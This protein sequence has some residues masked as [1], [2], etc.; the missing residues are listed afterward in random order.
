MP[1][2]VLKDI[3]KKEWD[4]AGSKFITFPPGAKPGDI[5]IREV[6]L[7]MVDWDTP[8]QSIKFPVTVTEEGIDNGKKDKVSAGV[9][10]KSVW[11]LKEIL[12]TLGVE[13]KVVNGKIAFDSDALTGMKTNGIWVMQKG[14][15]GG[16]PNA[17]EVVYPKLT[18]FVA[19]KP[20]TG[21]IM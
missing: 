21:T 6:E 11:K 9:D 12:N 16:D 1:Q 14:H 19:E 7:G 5:Q 18:G 15:K 8:G 10:A 17:E 20:A 3:N 13:T 2:F 4:T